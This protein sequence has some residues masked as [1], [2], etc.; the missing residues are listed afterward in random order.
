MYLALR[1]AG[2][3]LAL[4]ALTPLVL[5]AAEPAETGFAARL[6]A[7]L[8]AWVQSER[9]VGAVVLVARDGEVAYQRAVGHADRERRVPV[10]GC[11]IFRLASMTKTIVSA[12]A[13]ALAERGV[14]SLDDPVN[15]WLPQF[16]PALPDGRQ[17][18]ITIRQLMTHTSGLG[19]GFEQGA[20]S[21]YRLQGVS[22]GLDQ[23]GLTMEEN[24]RRLAGVPLLFEPGTRW[25]YSLSTDVLGAV[26]E[27][28]AGVPLPAA[29][30]RY[31][32]GPL[33][34]SDTAF[35]VTDP[36]RLAVPYKDGD[37]K[38][39]RMNP[40]L[41]SLPLGPG[42][43]FSARRVFDPASFPSGGAGMTGT[44]GDYLRFLE[45]LRQ[46]G[47]P[48]LTRESAALLAEH[49]IGDLRAE[50]EGPGW[51]FS[52][53]A[54]VLLDPAAAGTPQHAGTWQWGGVLGSHWFVDPEERLTM[55]VLTNTAIAGVIGAF[56]AELRDAIYDSA[57]PD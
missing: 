24:L 51:G 33:G 56:P 26:I 25:D 1:K 30:A 48:I 38:A 32:T 23:P 49:A 44:A 55:V 20:Q 28:A 5:R 10:T 9:I 29:V 3:T 39:V 6:D 16:T 14:L 41:D 35:H 54:A 21:P 15:A 40:L 42:I 8:D 45:A 7:V 11:T 22:T 2:A 18:V 43:P 57:I 12:T 52:L 4:V 47:A 53:G 27:N 37:P 36:K 46:G 50:S 19:Y 34:M 13:L 17:P 31:V